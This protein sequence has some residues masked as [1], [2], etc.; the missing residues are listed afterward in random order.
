M[1]VMLQRAFGVALLAGGTVACSGGFSPTPQTLDIN[2]LPEVRVTERAV[3]R[4]FGLDD[5]SPLGAINSIALLAGQE[6]I[7]VS[8]AATA[9]QEV[10][11]YSFDGERLGGTGEI[12]VDPDDLRWIRAIRGSSDG[13]VR[14]WNIHQPS[15]ITLG[16][17]LGFVGE[18][19]A[20]LESL[21]GMAPDFVDFLPD[22]GYLLRDPVSRTVPREAP[23]G[24]WRDTIQ[25]QRFSGTGQH[26][27]TVV[28]VED[29]PQ[30][31]FRDSTGHSASHRPVFGPE[32][33]ALVVNDEVWVGS[34][35]E[36]SFTRH[37][38]SGEVIGRI[39]LGGS[40]RLAS[41]EEVDAERERRIRDIFPDSTFLTFLPDGPDRDLWL[42]LN[43]DR[44]E[45]IRQVPSRDTL[46]AYDLAVSG[47]E[48]LV[49]LRE[50]PWP[51]DDI[52]R[53]AL[54]DGEGLPIGRVTL[55]RGAVIRAASPDVLVIVE[56]TTGHPQ[57]IRILELHL[58]G[59]GPF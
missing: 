16:A 31:Q 29:E 32:L 7:A 9:R 30:W 25:L 49:L 21:E 10:L 43:E 57:V 13:M 58:D 48:G 44:R 34:T 51:E 50:Y 59:V 17:D 11:R 40:P 2:S 20:D 26:L 54:L 52:T 4:G 56:G 18:Q 35:R 38:M 15:V 39:E 53:W 22:G 46:P 8:V 5:S 33:K 19:Q 23:L 42:F 55:P 28:V 47:V 3:L 24:M 6:A 27:D 14:V 12:G 37:T 45:A 1:R 36:V 41:A